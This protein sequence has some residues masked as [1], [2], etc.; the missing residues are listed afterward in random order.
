[1]EINLR[2]IAISATVP[3]LQDIATW[4]NA[5]REFSFEIHRVSFLS[6]FSLAILFSEEYR[7]IKLERFVYGYPQTESNMFL[8]ERNLN[9]K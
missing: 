6:N 4:L 5:K 8:F 7:P 9:W 2:Y 3:N 1:M